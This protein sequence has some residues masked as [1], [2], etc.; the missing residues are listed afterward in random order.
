MSL[1]DTFENKYIIRGILKAESPFRIGIGNTQ[2]LSPI[3]VDSPVIRDEKGDPFIPGSSLKGVL[4]TFTESI[5][6]SGA[7]GKFTACNIVNNPCIDDTYYR[8]KKEKYRDKNGYKDKELAED[9]YV[10][11]CDVCKLFGGKYFGPKI[12]ISDAKL[13]DGSKAYTQVR[14]GV[15]INRDTLTAEDGM[16]YDFECVDAGCEFTLEISVDNLDE[17]YEILLKILIT[18]LESGEMKIG[19]KTSSGFG[20]VKLYDAKVYK[21]SKDDMDGVRNYFLYGINDNLL[22]E[23][24]ADI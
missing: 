21:I 10:N 2:E 4:R 20:K 5:I 23:L 19:G 9:I 18:Y 12:C 14:D 15:A 17:E 1:L 13:R 6:N 16:K 11:E 24:G 8:E 7:F 22:Y 3:S